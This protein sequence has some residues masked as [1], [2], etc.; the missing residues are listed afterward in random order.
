MNCKPGDLAYIAVDPHNPQDIGK[1]V[2]VVRAAIDWVD[3]SLPEWEC[4]A[5]SDIGGYWNGTEDGRGFIAG[6]VVDIPDA[7]LRPI[8]GVPVHDEQHDEVSA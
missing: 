8:S 4:I 3:E 5:K 2:Q 6:G 7:W 1:V